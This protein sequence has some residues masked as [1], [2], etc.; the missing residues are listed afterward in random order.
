MVLVYMN[1]ELICSLCT[2]QNGVCVHVFLCSDVEKIQAGIGDKLVLFISSASTFLANFVV[3]FYFSWKMAL[4]VCAML[5]L[6]VFLSTLMAKVLPKLS[7][8]CSACASIC[9]YFL[10][11]S[12]I[13]FSF[14]ITFTLFSH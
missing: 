4:V 9:F 2:S 7:L 6:L 12:V 13:I 3:A 11:D 10:P 1:T 8:A 5:P 14:L